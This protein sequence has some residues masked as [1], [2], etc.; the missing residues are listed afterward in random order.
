MNTRRSSSR[1]KQR[2]DQEEGNSTDLHDEEDRKALAAILT[3]EGETGHHDDE[4]DDDGA[5][6]NAPAS[7]IKFEPLQPLPGKQARRTTRSSAPRPIPNATSN[8]QQQSDSRTSSIAGSP[9]SGLFINS[10]IDPTTSTSTAQYAAAASG[11]D[12]SV[13]QLSHTP[14]TNVATS[15]EADHFGKRARAGVS[16]AETLHHCWLQNVPPEN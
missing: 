7:S 14:P 15:Y 3:G 10:N 1:I 2:Q 4:S 16:I 12:F 6:I 13:Q 8:A 9:E 11:A 5:R